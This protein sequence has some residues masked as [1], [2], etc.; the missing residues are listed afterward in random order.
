MRICFFGDSF[1]NG[2]GDDEALGWPGRLVAAARHRGLDVTYYNLGIRRDTSDEIAARWH[3]EAQRRLPP[4]CNPR[5]AFSFGTNDC[6]PSD[7]GEARVPHDRSLENAKSILQIA[8]TLAPTLMIGPP[9]IFHDADAN[10]RLRELSLGLDQLCRRLSVPFLETATFISQCE[11]WRR[12]A[13]SGDGAH[14]NKEGYAALSE[15]V[16][17]WPHYER[18]LSG[19]PSVLSA[20]SAFLFFP[21]NP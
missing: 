15:H 8:R 16:A 18:W 13:D 10:M 9:P 2:T 19:Q 14:P 1:V 17:A 12:E 6:A 5:L 20:H 21:R 7:T 4:R 11:P 3:D